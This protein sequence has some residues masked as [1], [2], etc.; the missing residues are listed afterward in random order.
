MPRSVDHLVA[1]HELARRRVAA[2]VPVWAET[3][4]LAGVFHNDAM[5]FVQRRD[6]IVERLRATRWYRNDDPYEFEGVRDIVDDHLAHGEDVNEFYGWW[7]ELYD[8][9]NYARV[10]ITTK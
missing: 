6:A 10:A 2:G 9:A 7:D 5:T 1:V 8:L 4:N 3:I